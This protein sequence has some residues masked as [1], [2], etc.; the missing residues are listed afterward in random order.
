MTILSSPYIIHDKFSSSIFSAF[1]KEVWILLILSFFV[2]VT[3]HL[4]ELQS[5]AMFFKIILDYFAL[6][7]GQS[8]NSLKI[9]NNSIIEEFY[10]LGLKFKSYHIK[11]FYILWVFAS[12]IIAFY[13][14]SDTQALL[15]IQKEYKIESLKQLMETNERILVVR[16]SIV[17]KTFKKVSIFLFS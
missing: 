1:Q 4:I 5:I 11:I 15:V 6:L 8:K 16:E 12:M 14:V 13:F 17:H 10:I 3:I 7:I 2:V 9:S